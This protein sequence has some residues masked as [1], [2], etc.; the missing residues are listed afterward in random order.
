MEYSLT[1]IG[2]IAMLV[3]K[4]MEMAGVNLGTEDITKFIEIGIMIIGGFIAFYGRW[5]AGQ[6][7]WFGGKIKTSLC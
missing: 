3:A 2:I 6:I 4:V 1:Y 7:K 5:R